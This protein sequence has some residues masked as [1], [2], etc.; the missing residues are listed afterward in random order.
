M[1][2]P[3]VLLGAVVVVVG[4]GVPAPPVPAPVLAGVVAVPDDDVPP[5]LLV[6]GAIVLVAGVVVVLVDVLAELDGVVVPPDGG[7]V[8]TGVVLGTW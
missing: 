8:S 2:V 1:L 4:A 5:E 3:P 6:D 7:A